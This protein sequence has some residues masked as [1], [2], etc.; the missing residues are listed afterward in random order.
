[1]TAGPDSDTEMLLKCAAQGDAGAREQLL[2]RYRTRLRQMINVRMDR[3]LAARIDPSDVVQETLAAA[4]HELPGYLQ[5]R[6]LPFYPW[7]RRLALDRLAE[8]HRRHIV[9]RKRSVLRERQI[10]P[11]LSGES[12]RELAEQLL[13][14]GSNPSSRLRREELLNGVRFALAQLGERDREVLVLRHLEQLSTPEIA[15]IMGTSE[16]AVYTRHLRA[17]ERLRALLGDGLKEAQS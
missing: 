17:L 3:R 11:P 1:M 7:L 13:A 5:Q 2:V 14:R 8:L 15:A 4:V 10:P 12:S 9:A 6:P 16:G